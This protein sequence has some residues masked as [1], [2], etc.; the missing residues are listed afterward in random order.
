MSDQYC[1]I[2]Q[3][4]K[5]ALIFAGA[6]RSTRYELISPYV[7]GGPTQYDL[8]M[9]RKAEILQYKK[10]N[11]AGNISKKQSFSKIVKGASQRRNYSKSQ[12]DSIASGTYIEPTCPPTLTTYSDVPGPPMYLYLDPNISLY[13]YQI[14]RTYATENNEDP[15]KKW[16]TILEHDSVGNLAKLFTLS[17]TPAIDQTLYNFQFTTPIGVSI[18]GDSIGHPEASDISGSFKISLVPSDISVVIKY[19]GANTQ[20]IIEPITVFN[21][22]FVPTITGKSFSYTNANSFSGTFFIGNLTIASIYLPTSPGYTYEF[23]VNYRP[24]IVI[25]NIDNFTA[26]FITGIQTTLTNAIK[27][28]ETNC[29]FTVAPST[30]VIGPNSAEISGS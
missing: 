18:T 7:A 5:N 28:T 4:R 9:R 24:D 1:I 30:S 3:N 23:N 12:L 19:G 16:T 17:I 11:P 2:D 29:V 26:T 22:G 8:D 15:N 10:N 21:T 14:S 25:S 13:N 6:N 27:K 20:Q